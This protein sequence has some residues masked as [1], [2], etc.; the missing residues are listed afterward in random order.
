MSQDGV[1]EEYPFALIQ[2]LDF[3]SEPITLADGVEGL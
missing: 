3:M 2:I 1:V